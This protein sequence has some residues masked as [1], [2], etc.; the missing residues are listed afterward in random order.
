M[1]PFSQKQK[2]KLLSIIVPI[3]NE[4]STVVKALR[5]LTEISKDIE[6]KTEIIVIESNSTDKTRELVIQLNEDLDFELFL[7]E[8]PKGKGFAVRQGMK[9]MNGDVFMIFDADDEYDPNDIPK[10]IVPIEL[11]LTSFVLGS[12]HKTNNPMRSF[13]RN[14]LIG[15]IMNFGHVVFTALINISFKEKLTD[16]FTMYKLFR[17]EVFQDI[18]LTSNRFDFDW[19]LVCLALRQGCKPIELP[20]SYISRDYSS[21]KKVRLIYD[22]LLWM[23]ALIK[24]RFLPIKFVK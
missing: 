14:P 15:R 22:P 2:I 6:C 24:F 18:N 13:V 4:E 7:E 10:L 1:D 19:E 9:M 16:P 11:G 17:S 3:F 21:G 8:T 12:R 23:I 5:A 20:I